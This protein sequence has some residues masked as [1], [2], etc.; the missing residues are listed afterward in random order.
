MFK[1]IL[2]INH[3]STGLISVVKFLA[4]TKDPLAFSFKQ[5]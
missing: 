2:F 5:Q 1:F 3:S 4:F